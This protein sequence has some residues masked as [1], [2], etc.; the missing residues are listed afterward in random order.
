MLIYG[1]F[2]MTMFGAIYFLLPRL[3]GCEWLSPKMIRFHFWFSVYGGAS[4]GILLLLG[5][6]FQASSINSWSRNFSGAVENTSG[7]HVGATIG[8]VMLLAANLVFFLHYVLMAL[9]LGRRSE[10][11]MLLHG[12]HEYDHAEVMITTEGAEA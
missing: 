11:A 10:R 5:G 7:Y 9:R 8:W 12:P 2:T 6:V 4:V 1:Y 3:T